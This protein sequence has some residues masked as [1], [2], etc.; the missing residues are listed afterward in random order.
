MSQPPLR[1]DASALQA[2]LSQAAGET[3]VLM[4]FVAGTTPNSVE[5]IANTRRLCERHLPG[6]H[7][8]TI[9]DLYQQPEL[10]REHQIVAAPTLLRQ[11]PRPSRRLVGKL[12]DVERLLLPHYGAAR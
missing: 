8:L 9:V 11:Q 10:A 3:Y 2:A 4:L 7:R 6:R 12:D 5:A 1:G